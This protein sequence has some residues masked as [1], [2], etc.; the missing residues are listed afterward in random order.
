M[1]RVQTTA[2]TQTDLGGRGAER[3]RDT[4]RAARS[5][6]LTSCLTAP[7][8]AR[9]AVRPGPS[10]PRMPTRRSERLT[11]RCLLRR[12]GGLHGAGFCD[13]S[14]A[15]TAL[16][17]ATPRRLT[18]PPEGRAG[19]HGPTP[20][21]RGTRRCAGAAP[22]RRGR[23][24][25]EGPRGAQTGDRSEVYTCCRKGGQGGTEGEGGT[26]AGPGKGAETGPA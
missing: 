10:G 3:H 25:A 19:S 11:R 5:R 9:A 16:P 6:S 2:E 13:A 18:R 15:H 1:T 23:G 12:F 8:I 24:G 4:D 26:D 22:A 17:S 20:C 21:T 14:A 7:G